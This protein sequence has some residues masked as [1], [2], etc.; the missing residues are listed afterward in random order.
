[1]DDSLMLPEI[2]GYNSKKLPEQHHELVRRLSIRWL[3]AADPHLK[4]AKTAKRCTEMLEGIQWTE[5]EKAILSDMGRTSLTINKINPLYRLIM[6]YQSSNRNDVSFLPTSDSVSNEEV[7]SVLTALYKIES[8]REDLIYTDSDVFSDGI[9]GG[10]GFW[11]CYLNFDKNDL[12]EICWRNSDPFSKY[13]DPD[14]SSYDLDND[15]NGASYIQTSVWKDI[16]WVAT[17]Y[18]SEAGMAVENM[19]HS[20]YNSSLLYYLGQDEVSP[21]RYFGDYADDKAIR[22]WDDV[23]YTDFIDRQSKRIRLLDSEYKTTSIM[24]CFI[25][26][27]TGQK[28][29]IPT[30][31]LKPENQNKIQI[32]L[33]YAQMKNNPLKVSMRP[34]RRIRRTVTAGDILLYDNWS[35]YESYSTIGYFPYF[36]RGKTRGM[37]EDLIDPQRETNKKRSVLTDILNRN[38]NSGWIYEENTLDPEQEENLRQYGSAP[39]IH[40]KYKRVGQNSEAPRRL[41]PGGYPQGL[42]RLEEKAADDLHTI[43]GINESALGQLDRVQ[44]GRAIEA[45]Q[46]QAVLSIQMYSDNFSRSK[47]LQGRKALEIFQ[48]H[49]TEERIYRQLGEDSNMVVYEINK[50][51]Q[52]GD[53]S[54]MRLNDITIGN[55]SVK[56]DEVPIS[57]TFKQGQ[58]EETMMILEKLGPIGMALAQTSPDLI[59]DQTSLPRKNEWK[60]AFIQASAVAQAGAAVP[61]DP[62][63]APVQTGT[64]EQFAS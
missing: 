23:F 31:W 59:I 35:I 38:A 13:I 19:Y 20:G 54:V 57:A 47:K 61:Q 55:Y 1:M 37:V 41:E 12:G 34:V 62:N 16:D 17:N 46:R 18:G 58:F 26:L 43:S 2:Q 5:E 49:Y 50:K 33:D 30:E 39:G 3:R 45:R 56:V 8:D 15:E 22:T 14:C 6:G 28:E 51:M 63:A 36:R 25:D 42:D 27:E 21:G 9:I 32:A 10:R 64:P 44:S 11:D 53:N 40:V 7:A 4:W 48:N 29:P 52:T 24:P 60:Q